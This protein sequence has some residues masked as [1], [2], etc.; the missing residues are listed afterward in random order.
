MYRAARE[1]IFNARKHARASRVDVCLEGHEDEVVLTV[2]DD[3]VGSVA[4]LQN[5]GAEGTGLGLRALSDR[6]TSL[7]GKLELQDRDGGGI[8]IRCV[9]PVERA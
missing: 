4:S 5:R 3:G 9:L 6:F 8:Q 1:L 7:G 2:R